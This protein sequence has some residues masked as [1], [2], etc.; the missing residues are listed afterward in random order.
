MPDIIVFLGFCVT[1]C[2]QQFFMMSETRWKAIENVIFF[3]ERSI[4]IKLPVKTCTVVVCLQ[5][6]S[7]FFKNHS[8]LSII[9]F[10]IL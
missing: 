2:I 8:S 6:A 7:S 9:Y 4:V 10:P 5:L 3:S 1:Q